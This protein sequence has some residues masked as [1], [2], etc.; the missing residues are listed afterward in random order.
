MYFFQ[1]REYSKP[2]KTRNMAQK[3]KYTLF[4]YHFNKYRLHA[5]FE[6]LV[7]F[8]EALAKEG[9]AY[10]DSLFSRWKKGDRIPRER[11][12]ILAIIK[13]F[14]KYDSLK[15]KKEANY[16]LAVLNQR[17]LTPTEEGELFTY[18]YKPLKDSILRETQKDDSRI[19]NSL[20]YSIISKNRYN[21]V[22]KN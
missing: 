3:K 15:T 18:I 2:Y 13:V 12:L 19:L 6:T 16:L 10:E 21:P 17:D 11:K 20:Y 1:K 9:Y 4:A 7:Q 8:G 22:I 5:G 14:I